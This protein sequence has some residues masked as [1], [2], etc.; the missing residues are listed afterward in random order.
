MNPC[1]LHSPIWD[2]DSPRVDLPQLSGAL[3]V[4][5]CVVG[6]GGTGLS[7]IA[8]LVDA[9]LRVVGVDR[10]GIAAGAAGR[11]GGF[12][13]AGV[14]DFHHRARTRLGA[15]RATGLYRATSDAL[16]RW[17]RDAPGHTRQTG[18]LRIAANPLELDDCRRQADALSADGF[19]VEFYDGIQ[20][21]GLLFPG[22]GVFHPGRHWN[23]LAT[24][25]LGRGARMFGSSPVLE[26]AV[27][28]VS[29]ALGEVRAPRIL[30]CVDGGLE[31]LLRFPIHPVRSAR[32]QML[33]IAAQ[34]PSVD[35]P[36]YFRDGHDYWQQ[37]A[38]GRIALGG[39]RDI[40]GAAEWGAGA[41]P[42]E[43]VQDYLDG[44]AR[45]QFG[46]SIAITHRWAAEVAYSEDGLPVFGEM[47]PGLFASGAYSGTGNVLGALC[48]HALAEL[49]LARPNEIAE[50]LGDR[51]LVV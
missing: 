40:G 1:V 46:A 15:L 11:N 33:A 24:D 26:V 16:A 49:S 47:A 41:A 20:G 19:A 32:L 35:R 50:L 22:D 17:Y 23:A 10:V 37:L 31:R 43:V 9:G 34:S 48:G 28:R 29:T 18:S 38:D 25:L 14:A 12:L 39:G 4:D 6:L 7:A 36:V 3:S 45:R 42:G 21:K 2:D 51:A 5:A 30:I 27:G 13:L 8:T 44:V